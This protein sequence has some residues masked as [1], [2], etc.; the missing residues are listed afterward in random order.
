MFENWCWF[1]A[2]GNAE[3]SRNWPP[4]RLGASENFAG[5]ACS[6]NLPHPISG[7]EAAE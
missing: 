6:Q 5:N 1:P 7:R 4:K 3:G 2:G